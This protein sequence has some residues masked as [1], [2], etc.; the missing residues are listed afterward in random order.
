[1][2]ALSIENESTVDFFLERLCS[3]DQD[4]TRHFDTKLIID[5]NLTRKIVSSQADKTRPKYRWYKYKEAFSSDLVEYVLGRYGVRSGTVLDPFA[6]IGTAL[7][8]SSALGFDADGIELLPVGQTIIEARQFAANRTN[9]QHLERMKWW[10]TN[11]PWETSKTPKEF[12]VLRIS[13]GAYPE[14]TEMLIKKYLA[15]LESEQDEV[16]S[17]LL[18]AI[19]CVLESVSYTRKDGQ[20]LRWDYRSGRK[21]FGKKK[22]NKGPIAPFSR[23]ICRKIEE[24]GFDLE[25][26]DKEASLFSSTNAKESSGKIKL[27]RGSCLNVMPKLPADYYSAIITSPPYCNRY[28]YTRT[29]ALEHAI[30]GI[31][32]IE[33]LHLRQSMI[34]CTVENREKDLLSINPSWNNVIGVCDAFPLLSEILSYLHAMKSNK[35]LNNNGIPRMVK[36]YFYEMA[37]VIQECFRVLREGG[38]MFM[39]NDNVRYAGASI[40]VDLMLSKIAEDIGFTIENILFLPQAKGN[41][42]QQMG[43][44]GRDALRKCVY[45]WRKSH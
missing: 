1:M 36:G 19:L 39:V 35:A 14:E 9:K 16:A 25:K 26:P 33:N 12:S 28:D 24:I 38:M 32:D 21:G 3:L 43:V 11:K 30:L 45:V 41:S 8:A 13:K 20:Y 31:S 44:H 22:F 29:Y 2:F 40:P 17:L 4:L 18:F 6:G 27:F 7:F 37:C 42:S 15:C 34:S 10:V 23:A 5:R